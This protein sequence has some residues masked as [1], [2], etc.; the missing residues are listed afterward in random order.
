MQQNIL[1]TVKI[2]FSYKH[3]AIKYIAA[4]IF[5]FTNFSIRPVERFSKFFEWHT[6]TATS[7]LALKIPSHLITVI[8]IGL[9]V[10]GVNRS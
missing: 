3:A 9:Y 1:Y 5:S 2:H 6:G 10:A 8:L 7:K 4:S